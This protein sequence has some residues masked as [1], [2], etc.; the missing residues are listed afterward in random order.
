MQTSIWHDGMMGLVVG[1]ALGV[2]VEFMSREKIRRSAEGPVTGMRG[3]GSHN[4]PAGTWSDDSSLALATLVSLIDQQTINLDH[5]MW[6]FSNW[7]DCGDYSPF[8]E[9]FDEG[10]TCAEAIEAYKQDHDPKTCGRT[11][12]YA[13]G[14]GALMRILPVCLFVYEKVKAGAMTDAEAVEAVHEV[15]ALTHNHLRSC[16]CCGVYYFLCKAVLDRKAEEGSL[17]EIL[18]EGLD[19]AKAFYGANRKNRAEMEHFA[20]IWNLAQFAQTP[21]DRIKSSGYVIDTLEA[22]LWSLAGT[23]NYSEAVLRAVNLGD[24][25]DTVAAVTGGLAGLFYGAEGIPQEWRDTIVKVDCF[26]DSCDEMAGIRFRYGYDVMPYRE[27]LLR[28]LK[29]RHPWVT[30]EF[31]NSIGRLE[32]E[33]VDGEYE[34]VNYYEYFGSMDR[35]VLGYKTTGAVLEVQKEEIARELIRL[36]PVIA[37]YSPAHSTV[38]D[39]GGWRL[40][41]YTIRKHATGDYS[42]F[43][44]AGDRVSGGSREDMINPAAFRETDYSE[45]LEWVPKCGIPKEELMDDE[46]LRA[47]FGY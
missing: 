11:G 45:F 2:P 28:R 19:H 31:M 46:G 29:V 12:T 4:M 16:M 5:I 14:N 37:S 33:E 32:I 24:D 44:Q 27:E 38:V 18:Q 13:N 34:F 8:R 23:A 41:C 47:F 36:N 10:A 39:P 1:D 3:F 42:L 26:L 21:E 6:L 20:R 7:H 9:V 15:A 43:Q 35:K 22:A 25:T 30:M 17:M 40:E